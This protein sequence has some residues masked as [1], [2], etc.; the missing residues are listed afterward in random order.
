MIQKQTLSNKSYQKSYEQMVDFF[1]VRINDGFLFNPKE[2]RKC[3]ANLGKRMTAL[4]RSAELLA[5]NLEDVSKVDAAMA[6]LGGQRA[7]FKQII[8]IM[9]R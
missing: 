5:A 4:Q 7:A 2:V 1:N 8:D 6:N 9:N 3:Y